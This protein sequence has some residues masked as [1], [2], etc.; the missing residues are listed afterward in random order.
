MT[1]HN[2]IQSLVELVSQRAADQPGSLL[3]RFLSTGDIADPADEMTFADLDRDARAIGTWLQSRAAAGERIVLLYPPGLDFIRA[4]FGCAFGQAIAVPAFPPDPAQLTRTLPRLRA[5]VADCSARYVFTTSDIKKLAGLLIHDAPELGTVEWVATDELDRRLADDW[6][7][8]RIHR[9]DTAMLQYTSGS[10]GT[11]KGVVLTH[12]N[13]LHNSEQIRQG[14]GHDSSTIGVGW[15]PLYHDMGLSGYVIQPLYYGGSTVLMSPLAFLEQPARWLQA[16]SHFRATT[17]GGPNFAYD[18]CARK[19]TDQERTGLDLSCWRVAFNGSEPI[20]A[21]T[22]DR[23]SETFAPHGFKP[24]AFHPCYG[25]AEATLYVTGV[26]EGEG[27][28][29]HQADA[30]ALRQGR[31]TESSPGDGDSRVL[32]SCGRPRLNQEVVVVDPDSARQRAAGEVGEIWVRGGSVAHGYWLRPDATARTFGAR[33]ADDGERPFLRTGDLG[34][35]VEG[36]LYVV[37]R[38]KDLMI[39]NG[40]NHYP[41]DIEHTVAACHPA[42]RA[43]CSAVFSV[44]DPRGGQELPVAVAEIDPAKTT[45][46]GEVIEAVRHAVAREHRVALHGVAL[47]RPRTVAKTTSGKIQRHAVRQAW[48]ADELDLVNEWRRMPSRMLSQRTGPEASDGADEAGP[49][50]AESE[51]LALVLEAIGQLVDFS[52]AESPGPETRLNALGLDSLNAAALARTLEQRTGFRVPVETTAG[53]PSLGELAHQLLVLSQAAAVAEPVTSSEHI[54][55]AAVAD[56]IMRLPFTARLGGFAQLISD[57]GFDA[58]YRRE[59]TS[60]IGREV[61]VLDPYTLT[62][63]KMLMFGSNSYLSLAD[64][65]QVADRVRGALDSGAVGLGGAPLLSG[66]TRWHRELEQRLAKLKGT[67][68]ALLFSSGY[69]TN[70][71]VVSACCRP[72]SFVLVDEY[73]H[74]SFLDGLKMAR[75]HHAAF[76]HNDVEHL[77]QLLNRHAPEQSDIFIGIEGLYS[78]DGDVAP[79]DDITDLADRFDATVILDEAHATGVLGPT[80]RGA[81][82]RFS[83]EGR[84]PI[85]TGTLSKA[86][87]GL[88]GFAC[89]S[90]ELIQYLRLMSRSNMFSTAM[91]PTLVAQALGALDVLESEPGLLRRLRDNIRQAQESFHRVGIRTEGDP[92]SPIIPIRTP[93]TMD[94]RAASRK[95]H[96]AGIFVNTVEYPAV[97]PNQQRFRVSMMA[98]HTASDIERMTN[99]F[100]DAWSTLGKEEDAWTGNSVNRIPL[101]S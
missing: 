17:S 73:M 9:D 93:P 39:V 72:G 64:H 15:L 36:E 29:V 45:D 13:F 46:A 25:L 69:S 88:G 60:P 74:A 30:S 7:S 8:P 92:E 16:I 54:D 68:D 26:R 95:M 67:E 77:A 42:I 28:A 18:L 76:R 10:T 4:V 83:R 96:D 19:I 14:F 85:I 71:G 32:V 100:A 58:H 90:K 81:V 43:G 62:E 27:A 53:D 35:L 31:F 50:D 48:L 12:G 6:H 56:P 61:T 99:C 37:G 87:A 33:L 24:A 86:F 66:F 38:L 55:L 21:A 97:P 40:L 82:E 89:G 94:I 2:N 63:K 41:E 79:V 23:F 34:V 11:P 1:L 3:Y 65:P 57:T 84:V 75:V 20:R 98:S 59:I 5:I 44:N 49:Q 51:L 22:L 70:L 78:M 52:P 101:S 91:P 47:V 80:G